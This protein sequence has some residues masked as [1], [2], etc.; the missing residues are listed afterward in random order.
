[1]SCKTKT[2]KFTWPLEGTTRGGRHMTNPDGANRFERGEF[3][4]R[5]WT[6]STHAPGG[7]QFPGESPRNFKT[8]EAAS[9]FRRSLMKKHSHVRMVETR[10]LYT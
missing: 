1:M 10:V 3:R 4:S 5:N 9:S 7:Y 8:Y 6:V 2:E